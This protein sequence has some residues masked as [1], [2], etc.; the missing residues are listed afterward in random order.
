MNQTP[1]LTFLTAVCSTFIPKV[2][3]EFAKITFCCRATHISVVFVL[4]GFPGDIGVPGPNGPPGPK[5]L[6]PSTPHSQL[7]IHHPSHKSTESS[8]VAAFQGLQGA[9]GP[10]GPLGPQG[11]QVS[12]LEPMCPSQYNF[13][14][15][16]LRL[17]KQFKLKKKNL[18]NPFNCSSK[19]KT[20]LKF[21]SGS[22]F[23]Q[24]SHSSSFHINS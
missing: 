6:P 3:S 11:T 8:P 13:S 9:R 16:R 4:Q 10:P 2:L 14:V 18:C 1:P 23:T 12:H 21:D 15:V 17:E 7:C 22:A 24:N 20:S 19:T 5:V